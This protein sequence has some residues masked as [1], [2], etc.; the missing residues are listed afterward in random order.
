M[1]TCQQSLKTRNQFSPVTLAT[2][3]YEYPRLNIPAVK[4]IQVRGVLG[5]C[6]AGTIMRLCL[7]W[8]TRVVLGGTPSLQV[9]R[10]CT[11]LLGTFEFQR[12]A[13]RDDWSDD[14]FANQ[15]G[16]LWLFQWWYFLLQKTNSWRA[17]RTLQVSENCYVSAHYVPGSRNDKITHMIKMTKESKD[18]AEKWNG[19][20]EDHYPAHCLFWVVC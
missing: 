8:Q 14:H 18:L 3:F 15:S 20:T 13:K 9:R 4:L 17:L 10:H 16:S 19:N 6:F 7:F 11:V 1:P 2:V 5:L 12:F